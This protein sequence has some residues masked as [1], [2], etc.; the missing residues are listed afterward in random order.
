M[1]DMEDMRR[2]TTA[3]EMD[4]THRTLSTTPNGMLAI[5][6]SRT[7]TP[8]CPTTKLSLTPNGKHFF[9]NLCS[10]KKYFVRDAVMMWCK[11]GFIYF[12]VVTA[13]IIHMCFQTPVAMEMATV[14]HTITVITV[15]CEALCKITRGALPLPW[16]TKWDRCSSKIR[17]HMSVPSSHKTTTI[18]K[19]SLILRGTPFGL[20]LYWIYFGGLIKL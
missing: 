12:F 3:R 14:A 6:P 15:G 19:S 20:E 10:V 8:T 4:W 16:W 17:G 11:I 18:M 2:F 5:L 9:E 1:G 7:C 13:G